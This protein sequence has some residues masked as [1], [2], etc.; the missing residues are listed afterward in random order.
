MQFGLFTFNLDIRMVSIH[1]VHVHIAN[2]PF[3][4][5]FVFDVDLMMANALSIENYIK[6]IVVTSPRCHLEAEA[7]HFH[8]CDGLSPNEQKIVYL[9]MNCQCVRGD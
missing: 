2:G 5:L 7:V 3:A 6:H 1:R 4:S 8:F 9:S